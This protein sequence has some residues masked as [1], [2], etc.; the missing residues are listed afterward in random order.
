[1][2]LTAPTRPIPWRLTIERYDRMTELG[3]FNDQRVELI[4]GKIIQMPPQLE[5]H[6]AALNLA[7]AAARRAFGDGF[8]VRLQGPLLQGK[9]SKP[10]P[11]VAVVPGTERD[12][13]AKGTPVDALLIIEVSDATLR[14]DRGRKASLY[15]RHGI[16][17]YWI[18]NLV[19]RQLEVHRKPIRDP[20]YRYQYRY[21]SIQI[22]KPG[23]SVSA[24]AAPNSKITVAELLP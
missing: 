18:L 17:D 12:Y 6:F 15:A 16:A 20:A 7:G 1:M 21:A 3:W 4:E 9:L 24:L 14:Y 5:P 22:L 13:V 2:T 8:Y 23:D 11:D 10:E 19:D